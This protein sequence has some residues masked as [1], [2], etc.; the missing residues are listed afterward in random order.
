MGYAAGVLASWSVVLWLGKGYP[1][2]RRNIKFAGWL[3]VMLYINLGK[4]LGLFET[5]VGLIIGGVGLLAL[6]KYAP[7]AYKVVCGRVKNV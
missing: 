7:K 1:L 5:G 6:L 3:I 2:V 4:T